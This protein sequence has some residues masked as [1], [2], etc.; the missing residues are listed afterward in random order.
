MVVLKACNKKKYSIEYCYFGKKIEITFNLFD[1]SIK[2][3][4]TCKKNCLVDV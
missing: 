3:N 1:C 2:K 4:V